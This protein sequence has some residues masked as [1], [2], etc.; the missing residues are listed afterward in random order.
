MMY[1]YL[2]RWVQ[3]LFIIGEQYKIALYRA[4]PFIAVIVFGWF[5]FFCL[6]KRTGSR[7][8]SVAGAF[9][10]LTMPLV[11]FFSTLSYL[12]LTAVFFLSA[13]M[14]DID[15]LL[16]M[17]F[18]DLRVRSSWYFLITAGLIKETVLFFLV[19]FILVRGITRIK[20]AKER[21]SV[22]FFI[23]E[24][25]MA[26]CVLA[27]VAL[28]AALSSFFWGRN[29][30]YKLSLGLNHISCCFDPANYGLIF[31]TLLE[32][33][34]MFLVT[35]I[36]G[37]YLMF[38]KGRAAMGWANAIVFTG[39]IW[40][41]LIF[42][43]LEYTGYARWYLFTVPAVI[44]ATVYFITGMPGRTAK[45]GTVISLI[46]SNAI[47]FTYS[48]DGVRKNDW[49]CPAKPIS[50]CVYPFNDA[51][52]WISEQGGTK[53]VMVVGMY[54]YYNGMNYYFSKHFRKP[55]IAPKIKIVTYNLWGYGP[56]DESVL[57]DA[58]LK[59][60]ASKK[61]ALAYDTLIY[62]SVNNIPVDPARFRDKGFRYDRAFRNS[63]NSLYVFR[64]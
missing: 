34:G 26:F 15:A 9:A 55:R 21:G 31:H 2:S 49:G 54:Y 5:L 61:E 40:F 33:Y 48:P 44:C 56:E 12:D 38:R 24:S 6:K 30:F 43:P 63:R 23:E 60:F 62:L 47:L 52:K 25:V 4:V 57:L 8:M 1:P 58:F 39:T 42:R 36:G 59:D 7:V 32:S 22:S 27:P 19:V 17:E 14:V 51:V 29:S 41:F 46:L 37:I 64:R 53:N 10:I 28:F 18:K 16:N 13:A 50:E 11:N 35:M 45:W 3:G 20:Y